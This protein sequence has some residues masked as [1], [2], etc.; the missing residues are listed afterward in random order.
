[1]KLIQNIREKVESWKA[2]RKF[3]FMKRVVEAENP[4][5]AAGLACAYLGHEVRFN[6]T[7]GSLYEFACEKCPMWYVLSKED[8]GKTEK[9][10]IEKEKQ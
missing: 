10:L 5:L 1:M 9:E 2:K 4:Q 8:L 7:W 6:R 3:L